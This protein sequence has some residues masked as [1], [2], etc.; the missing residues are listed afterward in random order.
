MSLSLSKQLVWLVVLFSL[1]GCQANGPQITG[2]QLEQVGSA[3]PPI[4]I[5]FASVFEIAGSNTPYFQSAFRGSER[6]QARLSRLSVELQ[7]QASALEFPFPAKVVSF[8]SEDPLDPTQAQASLGSGRF[9]SLVLVPTLEMAVERSYTST[10]A[11]TYKT[12]FFTGMQALLVAPGKPF[13]RIAA[14]ASAVYSANHNSVQP[15]SEA[16]KAE[17]MGEL[18]RKAARLA[19]ERLP[20]QGLSST[21]G[22]EVVAIT[23]ISVDAPQLQELF[24]F[25]AGEEASLDASNCGSAPCREMANLLAQ[26]A[27]TRLANDG[28]FVLPPRVGTLSPLGSSW[29]LK[30]R[31]Y[32]MRLV[33]ARLADEE[34]VEAYEIAVSPARASRHAAVRIFAAEA[35]DEEPNP[36]VERWEFE[37]EGAI[38]WCRNRAVGEVVQGCTEGRDGRFTDLDATP[39]I[40][41]GAIPPTESIQR[42]GF[43]GALYAST[44][45]A[46]R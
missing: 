15:P 12:Q 18:Y 6:S 9:Y 22:S 35:K 45:G 33:Q 28:I 10:I 23:D 40:Y 32:T 36:Y 5:G 31:D 8:L 34:S 1:L 41:Q 7:E 20:K 16:F 46:T 39:I 38:D 30:A 21:E 24:E 4:L 17:R 37:V 14:A 3:A 29:S 44:L 19:L 42:W 11:T 27:S 13:A 2:S 26:I 25:N 43:L